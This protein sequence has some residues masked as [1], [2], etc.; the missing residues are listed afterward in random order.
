MKK[1]EIFVLAG[2]GFCFGILVVYNFVNFF[3]LACV[4]ALL[5]MLYPLFITRIIAFCFILGAFSMFFR[6]KNL[7]VPEIETMMMASITGTVQKV[8]FTKQGTRAVIDDIECKKCFKLIPKKLIATFKTSEP[9]KLGQHL[10]LTGL[11]IPLPK[12]VWPYFYDVEAKNKFSKIGGYISVKSFRVA[13]ESFSLIGVVRDYFLKAISKIKDKR[14]EAIAMALLLG[15]KG[16]LLDGDYEIF[17]KAGLAHIL[18][19]SGLHM[20]IFCFLIFG[21]C[22]QV[23]AITPLCKVLDTRKFSGIIGLISGAVYLLVSG[24]SI[25]GL[26]SF[27]MVLFLFSDFIFNRGAFGVRSLF[28]ALFAILTLFPEEIF[29]PS[30]Q[31]SFI[32]V[33]CLLKCYTFKPSKFKIVNI[34]TG[35]ATS[36]FFV[37]LLT[38]PIV[39]HHFSFFHIYGILSNIIAIP[40]L[41]IF[42]MPLAVILLITNSAIFAKAFGGS[43]NI[44]LQVADIFAKLPFSKIF[45]PHFSGILLVAFILGLVMCLCFTRKIIGIMLVAFS[46]I[47][48]FFTLKMPYL[49]VN[50][51]YI[52]I[53]DGKNY[54]SVFHIPDGFLKNIW[55]EKLN[56]HFIPYN[57]VKDKN[58]ICENGAC[59]SL[60]KAPNQFTILYDEVENMDHCTGGVLIN[61]ISGKTDPIKECKF[62][63]V[64]TAKDIRAHNITPFVL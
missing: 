47:Y 25:S 50:S 49:V 12:K 59:L 30:F 7:H 46:S 45:M 37:S 13:S 21:F 23:L 10:F 41:T 8:Y 57:T 1:Q 19:I 40:L 55:Q 58:F 44:M 2:C 60:T 53:K 3:F 52:V 43:I 6:M 64:I 34:I 56:T 51:Q 27:L 63:K 16:K 33:L 18:A 15:D 39:I 11:L 20:S 54:V 61:M 22:W 42:V 31:L 14:T 38:M 26:R 29:F 35:T 28:L 9:L 5:S 17:K 32:S 36:S 24:V 62:Q 4:I 48:Y